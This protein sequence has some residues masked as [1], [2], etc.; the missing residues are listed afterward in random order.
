MNYVYILFI[1][2]SPYRAYESLDA[3]K[4]FARIMA[5]QDINGTDGHIDE[6]EW[7][8]F[9]MTRED[10]C[11]EEYTIDRLEVGDANA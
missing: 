10:W 4:S 5:A 2:S 11:I 3:A 6:T 1:G 9:S 8:V 7:G